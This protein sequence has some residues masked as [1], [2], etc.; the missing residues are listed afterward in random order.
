MTR[1]G[2]REGRR[3]LWKEREREGEREREEG[4]EGGREGGGE[5]GR[6]T[7]KDVLWFDISMYYL[8]GVEV[9]QCCAEL[10]HSNGCIYLTEVLTVQNG[11]KQV[12]PLQYKIETMSLKL[13]QRDNE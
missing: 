8:I 13:L 7:Y 4:G 3:E 5:R 11:I 12:T 6:L 9:D 1:E 10:P 2:N